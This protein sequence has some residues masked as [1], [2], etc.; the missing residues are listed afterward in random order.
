MFS[1][2][3]YKNCNVCYMKK[4]KYNIFECIKCNTSICKKCGEFG[5]SKNYCMFCESDIT[6]VK[7]NV[8]VG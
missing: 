1:R 5:K 2:K 8:L 7:Y 4:L 6:R 3:Y